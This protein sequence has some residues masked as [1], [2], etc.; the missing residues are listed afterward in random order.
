MK[1]EERSYLGG[2]LTEVSKLSVKRLYLREA[3]LGKA[4]LARLFFSAM[5]GL[6]RE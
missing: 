6:N 4:E 2:S 5:P 1:N 3:P